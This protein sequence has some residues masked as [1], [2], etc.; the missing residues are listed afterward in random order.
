MASVSVMVVQAWLNADMVA[1]TNQMSR[2]YDKQQKKGQ[3][4]YVAE[5]GCCY[6]RVACFEMVLSFCMCSSSRL[7]I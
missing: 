4:K 5:D 1:C 3:C 7:G 6:C 2:A